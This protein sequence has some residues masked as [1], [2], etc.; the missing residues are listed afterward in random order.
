MALRGV[1]QARERVDRDGV[2]VD[3]DD[4]AEGDPGVSRSNNRQMRAQRPGRSSR[5]IGP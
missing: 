2:G 4:V 1:L 5:W 3:P